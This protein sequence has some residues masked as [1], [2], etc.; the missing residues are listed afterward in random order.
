[1]FEGQ[2]LEVKNEVSKL[3]VKGTI[4]KGEYC[5]SWYNFKVKDN[6]KF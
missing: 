3:E 1:M 5:S 4:T 2:Y 6:S